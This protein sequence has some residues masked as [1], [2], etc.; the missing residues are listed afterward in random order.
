MSSSQK[1]AVITLIKKKGKD[2]CFLE[3]WRPISLLN[4]DAKILSKVIATRIKKSVAN[5]IY[6]N[7][8]GYVS[9]R[10]IRERVRS[11]FDI[12]DF[13]DKENIPGL[14]IFIDFQK[15]FDT[16]ESSYLYKCLEAINFG[17]EFIQR[18]GHFIKTF[19]AA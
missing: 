12:M 1:Q 4:V 2:R 13:T 5:I 14:F 19:K 7:Q 17:E 9:D 18:V 16:L 8:S 3:N 15:A 10:Y 11:I 6:H